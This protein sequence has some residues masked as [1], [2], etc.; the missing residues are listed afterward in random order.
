[1][2]CTTAVY[3]QYRVE[4]RVQSP[5]GEGLAGASVSTR[6]RTIVAYTD[7]LGYFSATASSSKLSLLISLLGYEKK[8]LFVGLPLKN[9]A[10]VILQPSNKMLEEIE[11][12]SGYQVLPKE[13]ATGAFSTVNKAT[14]N[15]QVT[16][17]ILSRLEAVGNSIRVDRTTVGSDNNISIRGLSSIRGPKDILVV[18]D[19]FPFEGDLSS[20]NPNNVENITIQKDAAAA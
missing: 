14:F 4:G 1:A 16:P 10:V 17:D 6:D 15:E 9:P 13:R 5:A 3:G 20:L 19:N 2:C 11:V 18:V 12:S 7:S 8:E